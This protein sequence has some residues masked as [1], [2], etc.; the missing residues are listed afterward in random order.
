MSPLSRLDI[1]FP[2]N[3]EKTLGVVRTGAA[4]DPFELSLLFSGRFLRKTA[5]G[6]VEDDACGPDRGVEDDGEEVVK[7]VE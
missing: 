7:L 2:F 6:A 5:H 1:G 3:S 4:T